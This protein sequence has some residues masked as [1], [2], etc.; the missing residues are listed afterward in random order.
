[1]TT[2]C[3]DG[4]LVNVLQALLDVVGIEHGQWTDL[5]NVFASEGKD[6][7]I[8][9]HHHAEVTIIGRDEGETVL[10]AFAHA[11]GTGSGTSAAMRR[12]ER[13]VQVD[14]HHVEAHIAGATRSEHRVEV[15]SVVVHQ[16][17][18]AVDELGNLRDACLEE[19]QRVGVRHH[20]GSDLRTL[21]CYDTLQV[22]EVYR[23]VCERL[24]LDDL[25]AAH[26]GGGRIG[27]V[28]RVGHNNLLADIAARAVIVVDGHQSGQ[29]AVG[30]G[31]GLEGEVGEAGQFA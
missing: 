27:A 13:L 14:V 30:T 9:T 12:G 8:G 11:D 4:Q 29:L 2:Y 5:L 20:H 23:A 21:L 7:G 16:A 26:R 28:G 31:I 10:Q 18:A 1:M 17:A 25:Q 22:V 19:A 3:V 24:N 15:R 6:V